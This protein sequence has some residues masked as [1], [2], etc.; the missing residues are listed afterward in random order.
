[1]LFDTLTFPAA[2]CSPF[3]RPLKIVFPLSI[4]RGGMYGLFIPEHAIPDA[5]MSRTVEGNKAVERIQHDAEQV[6]I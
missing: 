2:P 3:F 5:R 4:R 1:M 6:S